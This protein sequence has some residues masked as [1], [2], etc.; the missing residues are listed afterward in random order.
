MELKEM[1]REELVT[2][3]AQ[4][5]DLLADMQE[6]KLLVELAYHGYK[7]TGKCWAAKVDPQTKKI[8]GFVDAESVVKDGK[9]T[10]YK[11]FYLADGHYLLCETGTKSQDSRRYVKVTDGETEGF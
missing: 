1:T 7:G 6:N 3:R 10:G 4:I 8:L 2:L 5:D 9:Y 11:T